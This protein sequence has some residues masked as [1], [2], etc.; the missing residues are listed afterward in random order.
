MG[1]FLGAYWEKGVESR[2]YI[3]DEEN[4]IDKEAEKYIET[5]LK[6]AEDTLIQQEVLLLKMSDY[7]SDHR[8]LEKK[9]IRSYLQKYAI[10]YDEN[11]MVENGDLVYYRNH[12]KSKAR[13]T[14][15]VQPIENA[16]DT[17]DI[18][19]NNKPG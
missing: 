10:N 9:E 14:E 19:L 16:W 8:K 6:L 12:L 7:L 13:A 1:K 15:N 2:N 18:S 5:A 4:A 11:S 17:F 3:H